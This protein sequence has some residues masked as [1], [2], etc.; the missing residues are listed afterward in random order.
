MRRVYERL[1]PERKG[2]SGAACL[3][4]VGLVHVCLVRASLVRV[5]LVLFGLVLVSLVLSCLVLSCLRLSFLAVWAYSLG[6]VDRSLL[7]GSI[8]PT[9]GGLASKTWLGCAS[10]DSLTRWWRGIYPLAR[11]TDAW[12]C[13]LSRRPQWCQLT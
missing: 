5:S 13:E 8:C 12:L 9:D 6:S 2:N 1:S 10:R 4:C 3:V 7:Q 11:R